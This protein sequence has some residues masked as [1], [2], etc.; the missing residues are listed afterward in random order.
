MKA[1]TD[2]FKK[3]PELEMDESKR[4]ILLISAAALVFVLGLYFIFF[5]RPAMT[6][7]FNLVPKVH[8]LKADI[9]AVSVDLQFEDKFRKKLEGLQKKMVNYEAKLSREKELTALYGE[10]KKLARRSRLEIV[11]IGEEDRRRPKKKAA[12]KKPAV[13]REFPVVIKAQSG[14]HEL[15]A[16][17]NSLESHE[18]FMQVS[19]IKITS[20]KTNTKKHDIEFVVKGYAFKSD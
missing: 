1:L 5:L 9:K 3:L 7:L 19:D 11:S 17:I 10:I 2:I 15:G 14:Y 13:Y 16:F 18:R 4:R 20:G 6:E 12:Q 8:R